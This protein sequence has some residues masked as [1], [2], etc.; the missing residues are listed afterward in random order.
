[1]VLL[2]SMPHSNKPFIF[3]MVRSL[4]SVSG[5]VILCPHELHVLVLKS[6][7]KQ[8]LK[9]RGEQVTEKGIMLL[10]LIAVANGLRINSSHRVNHLSGSNYMPMH[11]HNKQ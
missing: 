11:Y 2:S 7:G 10:T 6:S 4:V 3:C 5:S 9:K 8:N 1:M